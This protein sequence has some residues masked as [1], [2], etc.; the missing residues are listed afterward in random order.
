[1]DSEGFLRLNGEKIANFDEGIIPLKGKKKELKEALE[2]IVEIRREL[3][4]PSEVY[5]LPSHVDQET[6]RWIYPED[7]VE[8]NKAAYD[9]GR[10]WEN[11]D[12]SI[13]ESEDP[14]VQALIHLDELPEYDPEEEL[15]Q[16]RLEG[17]YRR[18]EIKLKIL[19]ELPN[20]KTKKTKNWFHSFF[21][22]NSKSW[23]RRVLCSFD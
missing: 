16:R 19:E 4:Y 18:G 14:F 13:R 7:F 21:A 20:V 22:I 5:E 6:R 2:K 10:F 8:A 15:R 17:E 9:F 1:M 12:K 3:S 11:L 23:L